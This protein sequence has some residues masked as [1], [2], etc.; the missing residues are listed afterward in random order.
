MIK[1]LAKQGKSSNSHFFWFSV[2]IEKVLN[3]GFFRNNAPSLLLL[4]LKYSVIKLLI[5]LPS[6]LSQITVW[7]F[8]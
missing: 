1:V 7:D 2:W 5:V 4:S 8:K 3:H 6:N